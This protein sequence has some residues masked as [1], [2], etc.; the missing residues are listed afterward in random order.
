[1]KRKTDTLINDAVTLCNE[2]CIK[3]KELPK[4]EKI[5]TERMIVPRAAIY[6]Q[7]IKY[8]PRE[9]AI[10]LINESVRIGVTPDWRHLHLVTKI[11]FIRPLFFKIFHK[12]LNTMFNEEAGFEFK[13]IEYNNKKYRV[14]VLK[15]PY[16]KYCELL[17]CKEFASTFC[18]SDD[19]VYGNMCDI[20]FERKGT[21]GRGNDR[22]EFYFH[23]N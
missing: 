19:Y 2:L 18:L 1:M 21:I 16:V 11:P 8:I 17:G 23:R 4:K 20:A 7:M 12:M 6:L 10:D 9:E 5:H 13:E 14:D 15:C 22:C 3:Y